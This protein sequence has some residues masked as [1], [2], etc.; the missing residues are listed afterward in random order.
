MKKLIHGGQLQQVAKN[1]KIPIEQWLDLSTGISPLSY[2]IPE[3]PSNIWQELPEPSMSLITAA[4]NY[5]GTNA[6]IA[7]SGSQNIISK[8][9]LLC[10]Q[11]LGNQLKVW[12]PKVGYKEHEKAWRDHGYHIHHYHD[13]PEPH[14]LTEKCVLIV[15]NPNNPSG[16]LYHHSTLSKLL[17]AV[18]NKGGWLVIDEAFMDVIS[19]SQ[20]LIEQ[21]NNQQLFVLRS[22]GKF[23]GLAGIRLG[24]VSAAPTWLTRLNAISSPWEVNGPA[25]FVATRALQDS[26]WQEN[27]RQSLHRLSDRLEELLAQ[28]FNT[29]ITGTLL[30][31]TVSVKN[32]KDVFD[33]LCLL[34]IYVRLCDEQDALRFGI[35]RESTFKRLKSALH[36]I[37][38][39]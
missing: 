8:L 16:E 36:I 4:K 37:Q 24:F 33:Q 20:T 10:Y 13:L 23:F 25:Q 6:L 19:P 7:T 12:L 32:A 14:E 2:P 35:P 27:Q 28:Y 26:H 5:Y 31:K 39:K 29:K 30:F 11:H 15:I 17:K 1:S 9:P 34:G 22:V 38:A 3:I 21:T 18:E